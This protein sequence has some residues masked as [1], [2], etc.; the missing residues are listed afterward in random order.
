MTAAGAPVDKMVGDD[1]YCVGSPIN[2]SDDLQEEPELGDEWRK[3]HMDDPGFESDDVAEISVW[4]KRKKL[5]GVQGEDDG[6]RR[7]RGQG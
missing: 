6:S 2:V 5:G 4:K 1:G 7:G 3:W